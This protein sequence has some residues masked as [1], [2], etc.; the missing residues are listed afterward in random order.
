MATRVDF[1]I[2][3]DSGQS[4]RLNFAC[5]LTEKAYGLQHRVYAHTASPQ[6]AQAFDE[7]LW[8]FSQG[9][10]VPHAL[11]NSDTDQRTPVM[12][13]TAGP[14]DGA[15]LL[16]NLTDSAPDFAA[17]FERV[18]EI[19]GSDENSRQAGRER[20]RQYRDMGLE[21]VTHNIN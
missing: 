10:F 19:V 15:D 8:T 14:Q 7:L 6:E 9:S 3:A 2:L 17:R 16:I 4:G 12:I 18:A 1:Y 20:Y 11:L 13:G 21:P 5:R